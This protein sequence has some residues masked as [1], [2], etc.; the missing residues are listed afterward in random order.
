MRRLKIA[1]LSTWIGLLTLGC[2]GSGG[3]G[4]GFSDLR[5]I[6][7]TWEGSFDYQNNLGATQESGVIEFTVST[8]GRVIGTITRDDRN[9]QVDMLGT[10]AED[11][12]GVFSIRLEYQWSDTGDRVASGFVVADRFDMDT[13]DSDGGQA[14]LQ[15]RSDGNLAGSLRFRLSRVAGRSSAESRNDRTSKR[16]PLPAPKG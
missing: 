6:A 1:L 4:G 15:V 13:A 8:T 10:I 5:D 9:E 11:E 12:F 3:D 16:V 2:G 7:G 14:R